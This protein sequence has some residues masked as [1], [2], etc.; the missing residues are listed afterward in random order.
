MQYSLPTGYSAWA[1]FQ[2]DGLVEQAGV[3]P[4]EGGTSFD[5]YADWMA[6]VTEAT[7]G[8]VYGGTDFTQRIQNFEIVLRADGKNL[9]TE[10][11]ELGFTEDELRDFWNSG[12]EAR[13]GVVVPQQR[14]E[15]ISPS[16][17]SARTSPRAR[18]AGATSSAAT[19]PTPAPRT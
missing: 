7:G 8:S 1:I 14:L 3:E 9:Y 15:E 11:G 19:S 2:N 18:R 10:D 5:E 17:A 16:R 12:A 13:D 4:Y 6:S